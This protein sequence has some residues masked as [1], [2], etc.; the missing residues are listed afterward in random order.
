[1]KNVWIA[2]AELVEMPTSLTEDREVELTKIRVNLIG[3]LREYWRWHY[4]NGSINRQEYHA[5]IAVIESQS[6]AAMQ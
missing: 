6:R 1:M 3:K 5:L 2:R 4:N